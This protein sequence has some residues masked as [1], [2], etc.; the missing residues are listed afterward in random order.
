MKIVVDTREKTPWLFKGV[1]TVKRRL[2][3]GD[4]SVVGLEERVAIE[5]KTLDDFVRSLTAERSRF[6]RELAILRRYDFAAVVVEAS[7][8]D[9]RAGDYFADFKPKTVLALAIDVEVVQGVSVVF[10]GDREAAIAWS[11]LALDRARE[12]HGG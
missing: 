9:I 10:A 6:F 4:Y 8:T 2:R 7:L 5:R 3:A 11:V 12:L 1:A